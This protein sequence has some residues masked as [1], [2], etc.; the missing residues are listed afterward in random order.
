MKIKDKTLKIIIATSVIVAVSVA[1]F[2]VV[3]KNNNQDK[4]LQSKLN[5]IGELLNKMADK[6]YNKLYREYESYVDMINE[7]G[8]SNEYGGIYLYKLEDLLE[9]PG[10]YRQCGID[11]LD[12]KAF[13]ARQKEYEEYDKKILR[14]K[15]IKNIKNNY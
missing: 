1:S 15:A 6:E 3:N 14:K 8:L 4:Q 13:E 7:A 9:S 2:F 5:R 10:R 12:L 11:S